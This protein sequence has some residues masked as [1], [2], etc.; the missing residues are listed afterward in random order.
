MENKIEKWLSKKIKE[1]DAANPLI[2]SSRHDPEYL[3]RL[4]KK[5]VIAYAR[6]HQISVNSRKKKNELIDIILRA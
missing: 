4:T 2:V 1:E 3:N 6:E 5:E